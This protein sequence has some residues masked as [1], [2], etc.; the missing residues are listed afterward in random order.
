MHRGHRVGILDSE[1]YGLSGI[2][3]EMYDAIGQDVEDRPTEENDEESHPPPKE[4]LDEDFAEDVGYEEN[5]SDTDNTLYTP[6]DSPTLDSDHLADVPLL[7]MTAQGV[8]QTGNETEDSS[9]SAITPESAAKD[10]PPDSHRS[11]LPSYLKGLPQL[12]LSAAFAQGRRGPAPASASKDPTSH[13]TMDDE[14][15]FEWSDHS[16][17]PRG[18]S[19]PNFS[20]VVDI[21]AEYRGIVRDEWFRVFGDDPTDAS[22][23]YCPEND[24]VKEEVEEYARFPY[25]GHR[26]D[27]E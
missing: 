21:V 12:T 27:T 9:S 16:S 1:E 24:W 23:P 10:S 22:N 14:P 7:G 25:F 5:Y 19:T 11:A 13:G 20:T 6:T 18:H 15:T 8:Q 26:V 3:E 4:A 2:F 17:P